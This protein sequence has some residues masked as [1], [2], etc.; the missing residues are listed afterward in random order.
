MVAA[1]PAG[2]H[3][4]AAASLRDGRMRR[5]WR[6]AGRAAAARSRPG[7]RRGD[8]AVRPGL[9][10]ARARR[11][12]SST[13]T[14]PRGCHAARR[15]RGVVVWRVDAVSP[16]LDADIERGDVILEINRRRSARR[17]LRPRLVGAAR[18]GDVL[19]FYVYKPTSR[20]SAR[21]STVRI[22]ERLSRA[23]A[24]KPRILVIDDEAAIRDSLRMILEYEDYQFVG[25]ASGQEGHRRG[26]ARAA[27]PRAARHQDAGHGRHGGAAQAARRS[28]RRCP[29]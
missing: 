23:L 26:A 10:R 5:R 12:A 11:C 16:A 8:R 19:T 1:P 15:V 20:R 18:P 6:E 3:R 27:R 2:R 14:S 24:M 29:S 9:P 22:D 7:R 17:R 21:L 28:T 13:P 25:A 4:D